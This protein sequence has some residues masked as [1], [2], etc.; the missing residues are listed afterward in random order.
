MIKMKDT[1]KTL[2]KLERE[3]FDALAATISV[4]EAASKLG[5]DPQILYNWTWGLKKK[6]ARRRG[7]INAVLAQRRRNSLLNKILTEKKPLDAP[8]DE[9]F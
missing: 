2:S 3:R 8:A 9:E 6:Y 5:L 7:W 4:K 1:E